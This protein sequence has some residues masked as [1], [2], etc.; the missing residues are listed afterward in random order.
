ML[1]MLILDVGVVYPNV[2]FVKSTLHLDVSTSFYGCVNLKIKR[3][4]K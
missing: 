2:H 4:S 3:L 1:E